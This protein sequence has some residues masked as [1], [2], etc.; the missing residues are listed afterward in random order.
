MAITISFNIRNRNMKNKILLS[1]IFF[2]AC[3]RNNISHS[4]LNVVEQESVVECS[5]PNTA[6]EAKIEFLF[7]EESPKESVGATISQYDI[8][9]FIELEK[10]KEEEGLWYRRVQLINFDCSENYKYNFYPK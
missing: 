2:I 6:Y 7:Y 10:N 4:G 1:S 5:H 9:V 8:F 3:S